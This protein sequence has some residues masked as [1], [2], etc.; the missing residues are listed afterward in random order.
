MV[1]GGGVVWLLEEGWC[2]CWRR[3]GVVD[4]GGVVWLMEEGWCGCWRRGGV[5]DGRGVVWLMEGWFL[6]E[7]GGERFQKCD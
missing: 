7:F 2:G 3:G 4:G 5:V 6:R 1:D